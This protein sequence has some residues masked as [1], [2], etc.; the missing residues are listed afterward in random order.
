MQALYKLAVA[1]PF[2]AR[3]TARMQC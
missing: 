2:V 3:N 1:L